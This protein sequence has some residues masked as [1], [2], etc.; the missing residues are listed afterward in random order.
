VGGTIPLLP[1]AVKSFSA[2]DAP[3]HQ[4]SSFQVL[5]AKPDVEKSGG[6]LVG[7]AKGE[8]V[9]DVI[10]GGGNVVIDMDLVADIFTE[11]SSN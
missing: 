10:A 4:V 5:F 8:P 2:V 6:V 3:F 7:P 11:S 9:N 1:P